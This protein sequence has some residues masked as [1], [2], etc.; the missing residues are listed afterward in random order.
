MY[1]YKNIAG[2][3]LLLIVSLQALSQSNIDL[4]SL[5]KEINKTDKLLAT[6]FAAIKFIP[7]RTFIMQEYEGHDSLSFYSTEKITTFGF[8]ISPYEVTNKQYRQFLDYVQDSIMRKLMG[9]VKP[10]KD[11]NEYNDMTKKMELRRVIKFLEKVD[12]CPIIPFT[13]RWEPLYIDTNGII[14]L[15]NIFYGY[16]SEKKFISI[17][18]MPYIESWKKDYPLT[19]NEP[20]LSNYFYHPAFDDYPVT[21]INFLQ[22][23]VYCRWKTEQL[24]N[25][26]GSNAE[27]DVTV[28]LP[29]ASQ[30]EAAAVIGNEAGPT[31]HSIQIESV[32]ETR[33]Y[34]NKPVKAN[35]KNM[36]EFDCNFGTIQDV[37]GYTIKGHG[38]DGA[39]FTMNTSA[40]VCA[41][42]SHPDFCNTSSIL[43]TPNEAPTAG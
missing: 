7:T 3:S 17:P 13:G 29:T 30:W 37:N 39:K 11:G 36:I 25:A 38:D 15:R 2:F 21:G 22:A 27:Y 35:V 8:Y 23:Q 14:R 43:L 34:Q 24:K 4:K 33:R 18:V 28:C 40:E 10:D 6:E 12:I 9:Y 26:L 16:R 42:L 5:K 1:K 20:M 19:Y 32:N 31:L 41:S